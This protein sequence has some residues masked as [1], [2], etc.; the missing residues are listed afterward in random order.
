MSG[1]PWTPEEDAQI[2]HIWQDASLVG[3]RRYAAALALGRTPAAV[4]RHALLLG[5]SE[6]RGPSAGQAEID[7]WR[8]LGLGGASIEAIARLVGRPVTT[9]RRLVYAAE[10]GRT[11]PECRRWTEAE[12]A[13]L[14]DVWNSQQVRWVAIVARRLDR[15]LAGVRR[16]AREIGLRGR[17]RTRECQYDRPP[18]TVTE[19]KRWRA[20]REEGA[21]YD[22]IARDFG[23]SV[24]TVRRHLGA[25]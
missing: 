15:P 24:L 6:P 14:R 22:R 17:R 3:S 5:L 23:R 20:A 16:H 4:E 7:R 25:A 8:A 1:R 13:V 19:V 10:R 2:R 12:D 9:V 18:I 11:R 21:T